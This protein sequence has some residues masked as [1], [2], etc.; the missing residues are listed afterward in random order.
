METT[1]GPLAVSG[2][3]SV[4]GARVLAWLTDSLDAVTDLDAAAA[5]PGG[6]PLD[7]VLDG[8]RALVHLRLSSE[9]TSQRLRR[10]LAAAD[11]VRHLTLVSSASV[12]GAWPN[13]PTPICEDLPVRPNLESP[14]AVHHADAERMVLGW[15]DEVPGRSVAILRP[16]PVVGAGVGGPIGEA[17]LVAARIRTGSH[18]PAVQFLHIDDL[19]SAVLTATQQR[20]SGAFNVA[21]DGWLT[22]GELR[23]LLGA[24]P[25]LWPRLSLLPLGERVDRCVARRVGPSAPTGLLRY[26]RHSWVV[27]NDR[28]RAQGWAP[29]YSSAQAY[30]IAD[31]GMPWSDLNAR[32]RQYAALAGTGVA[33]AFGGWAATAWLRRSYAWRT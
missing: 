29:R 33:V 9:V 12:Y 5:V 32:Q 1:E 22:P 3:G 10:V 27:A 20:L 14:F 24:R 30:V 17:M 31:A 13:H 21:P 4:I 28:L 11:G 18:D 19:A 26:T 7:E 23:A 6:P 8:S 15:R 2:A 25:K 16:A